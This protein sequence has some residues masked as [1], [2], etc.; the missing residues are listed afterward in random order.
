MFWF[1]DIQRRRFFFVDLLDISV[2]IYIAKSSTRA[3]YCHVMK[4]LE[5]LPVAQ[6]ALPIMLQVLDCLCLS[7][8]DPARK[9]GRPEVWAFMQ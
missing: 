3:F 7:V 8:R 1:Q 2:Y 4:G 5:Q 6:G 9:M